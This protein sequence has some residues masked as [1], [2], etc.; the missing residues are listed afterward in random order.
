MIY[1]VTP[2]IIYPE[3]YFEDTLF[4]KE[5]WTFFNVSDKKIIN[6]N[7]Q[8]MNYSDINY[9]GLGKWFA[10]AEVIYNIYKLGIY[11]DYDYIGFLHQ[12]YVLLNNN[13][14]KLI[15]STINNI[16][17]T[18]NPS[19]ISFFTHTFIQDYNQHIMMDEKYPNILVGNGRNCYYTILEQYNNFFNKNIQIDDLNN[20]KINLCSSFL[21]QKN[22]FENL[23]AWISFIIESKYLDKFDYDHKYR[24]HGGMIERYIAIYTS[25]IEICELGLWHNSGRK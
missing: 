18:K 9:I 6:D 11:K 21:L 16:I 17:E 23:M 25:Q 20:K 22:I 1:I 8:I 19:F 4:S 5:N 7:Y 15:T 24:F 13:K 14:N 10:E 12:D 2:G 3:Y